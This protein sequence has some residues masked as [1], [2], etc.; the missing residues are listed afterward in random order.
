MPLGFR[1]AD[2]YSGSK[3]GSGPGWGAR[4]KTRNRAGE[5]PRIGACGG[6]ARSDRGISSRRCKSVR[7]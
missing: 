5:H 7:Q 4:R 3:P 2:S 6:K 1:G